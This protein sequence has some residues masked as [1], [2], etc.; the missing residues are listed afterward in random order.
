MLGI[1]RGS[2]AE[3][4]TFLTLSE[5]LGFIQSEARDSVLEACAEINKMLTGL[6]RSVSQ[7]RA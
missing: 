4:E 1:A 7:K 2:L 5:R 6:M 3:L